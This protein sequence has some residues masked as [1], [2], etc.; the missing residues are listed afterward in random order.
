MSDARP[1]LRP[2]TPD[3]AAGVA[4]IYAPYVRET[5]IS[6]EIEPPDAGEMRR[7]IARSQAAHAWLVCA[8]GD[9]LL[10]YAYTSAHSERAAYRWG[11]D[12]A[13]YVRDDARRRGVGCAL[14]A[15]LLRLATAQGYVVAYAGITLPNAASVGL[16]ESLGFTPVGLYPAVG[17]KLGAWHDVGWWRLALRPA[18]EAPVA[19]KGPD[20][21]SLAE[22]RVAL[23][24]GARLV[25]V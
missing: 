6:F 21:L 11:V 18:S 4:A 12:V 13:V 1:H 17:Y 14:Y 16:H 22:W 2:A 8:A 23:A 7:R 10:G 24:S 15:A 20:E 25:R 5:P 9:A 3:D 19:P